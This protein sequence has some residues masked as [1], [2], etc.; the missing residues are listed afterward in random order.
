MGIKKVSLDFPHFKY[1]N[2]HDKLIPNTALKVNG[3]QIKRY[4]HFKFKIFN[5]KAKL[6]C[7]KQLN[8]MTV[9]EVSSEQKLRKALIKNYLKNILQ[10]HRDKKKSRL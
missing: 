5:F 9:T 1:V 10:F 7:A 6:R 8:I 2:K 3:N 4:E